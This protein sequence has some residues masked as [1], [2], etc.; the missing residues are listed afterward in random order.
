ML[1]NTGEDSE[2]EDETIGRVYIDVDVYQAC[3]LNMS[4]PK[5]FK[6]ETEDN[7]RRALA[8]RILNRKNF[9]KTQAKNNK[10]QQIADARQ[11]AK[12]AKH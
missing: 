10:A 5:G 12:D 1:P 3:I 6:L 8:Q 7:V 2:I 11:A 9:L 4:L